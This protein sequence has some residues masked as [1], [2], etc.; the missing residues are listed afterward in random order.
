MNPRARRLRRLRRK[1]RASGPRYT[2]RMSGPPRRV[3]MLGVGVFTLT[4]PAR[5]EP[6]GKIV[7]TVIP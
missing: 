6:S 2:L 1:A 5:V 3:V 4:A 7:R